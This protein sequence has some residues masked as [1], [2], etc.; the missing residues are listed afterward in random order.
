VALPIAQ[1]RHELLQAIDGDEEYRAA[2]VHGIM[3]RA[4]TDGAGTVLNVGL[5]R[6]LAARTPG[7]HTAAGQRILA[8]YR[9]SAP[10]G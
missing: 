6:M 8:G 3:Q 9:A 1:A 10:A 4:T 2:A 7:P 5:L